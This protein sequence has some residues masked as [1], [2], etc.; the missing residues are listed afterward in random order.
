MF[1]IP[2]TYLTPFVINQEGLSG[3]TREGFL[4]VPFCS[5]EYKLSRTLEAKRRFYESPLLESFPLAFR[6]T[7]DSNFLRDFLEYQEGVTVSELQG[8][9]FE[10]SL[11]EGM[12]RDQLIR[13]GFFIT[14]EGA[15]PLGASELV[16]PYIIVPNQ[17]PIFELYS[18]SAIET[19]NLGALCE[20]FFKSLGV[21]RTKEGY[22]VPV[23]HFR[24][25]NLQGLQGAFHRYSLNSI[26]WEPRELRILPTRRKSHSFLYHIRR[27]R[28]EPL[29]VSTLRSTS[30]FPDLLDSRE[31]LLQLVLSKPERRKTVSNLYY[32]I[33][34]DL[35]TGNQE[36]TLCTYSQRG[37]KIFYELLNDYIYY[38][39]PVIEFSEYPYYEDPFFMSLEHPVYF[40]GEGLSGHY[41][42]VSSDSSKIWILKITLTNP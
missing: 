41:G 10:V 33:T 7:S 14:L 42:R 36:Y 19:Y 4:E 29:F 15:T 39:Q 8:D 2:Y 37:E 20:G 24:I 16:E 11:D 17:R 32:C 23:I 1:R 13:L 21:S 3:G 28:G 27:H 35:F 9:L 31:G 25:K 34:E 26:T 18:Q 6:Y 22:R 30:Q 40:R 38:T 5:Q 12:H